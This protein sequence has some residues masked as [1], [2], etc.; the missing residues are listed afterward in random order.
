M[1]DVRRLGMFEQADAVIPG[2]RWQ[3]PAEVAAW[4]GSLT[5]GKPVVVYCIYGHEVGRSTA[6]R[7]RASG[8]EARFL[9]G[10]IDGWK[11]AGR[12]LAPKQSWEECHERPPHDPSA[13]S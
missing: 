1:L 7:L 9:R 8:V 4:A 6:M 5:S 2:A 12:P 10:G 13:A 11:A 3:D